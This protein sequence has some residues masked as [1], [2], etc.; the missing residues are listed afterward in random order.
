MRL[1]EH[2][3]RINSHVDINDFKNLYI[4]MKSNIIYEEKFKPYSIDYNTIFSNYI[5]NM[6]FTLNQ[7]IKIY[8]LND[9][10][11]NN[12]IY[13]PMHDSTDDPYSFYYLSDINNGIR[14]WKMD[15]RLED[16]TLDFVFN[17]KSRLIS[18]FK[19]I[20]YETYNDNNY[21]SECNE[22]ISEDLDQILYNLNIVSDFYEVSNQ[23]RKIIKQFSTYIPTENDRFN[24]CND[25]LLQKKRFE[26]KSENG[27]IETIELLFDCVTYEECEEY[28]NLKIKKEY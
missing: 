12:I 24:L 10:G 6:L 23:I 3:E 14:Y 28:C 13:V 26:I 8:F 19:K 7:I 17:Y 16:I 21:R 15:C 25:D 27:F 5:T 2:K 18:S 1:I 4:F 9:Y 22:G 20:Y 11:F